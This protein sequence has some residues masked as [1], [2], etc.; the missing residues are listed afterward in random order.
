MFKLSLR[1]GIALMALS[2]SSAFASTT[3]YS[4]EMMSPEDA[5]NN[6][7][8]FQADLGGVNQNWAGNFPAVGFTTNSR[9]G[10]DYDGAVGYQWSRFL[11]AEVGGFFTSATRFIFQNQLADA[12]SW[13]VDAA[14]KLMVP[15]PGLTYLDAFCKFGI[16][17]RNT[18]VTGIFRISGD[19][20]PLFA[21]GAQYN[22][23]RNWFLE[24]QWAYLGEGSVVAI[25]STAPNNIPGYNI[26]TIGAGYKFTF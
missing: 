25:N 2:M 4:E 11:S 3:V 22:I 13:A 10:F 21:A 5:A 8:Y 15:I 7:V 24:L 17:Y 9:W 1:V 18:R 23:T 14:G 19:W 12:Q 20:R 26:F 16:V 6:G